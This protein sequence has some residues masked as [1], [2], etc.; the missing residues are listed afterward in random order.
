MGSTSLIPEGQNVSLLVF[1]SVLFLE[2]MLLMT[3]GL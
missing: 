2:S 1:S 3:N